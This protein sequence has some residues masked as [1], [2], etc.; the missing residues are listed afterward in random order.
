MRGLILFVT[1]PVQHPTHRP[2]PPPPTPHPSSIA[3]PPP[4]IHPAGLNRCGEGGEGEKRR[5]GASG[6][7]LCVCVCT[8][9]GKRL[10]PPLAI[11][12]R[13]RWKVACPSAH[14]SKPSWHPPH[15]PTHPPISAQPTV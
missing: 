1:P 2:P 8:V 5:Q 15:P 11:S 14:Q 7:T 12:F 9:I 3:H 4:V 13:T 6:K 10:S